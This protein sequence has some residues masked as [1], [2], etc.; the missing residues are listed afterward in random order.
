MALIRRSMMLDISAERA[1]AAIQEPRLLNHIAY[2]LQTFKPVDPPKLPAT[3]A[4]SRYKVRLRLFGVVPIGEQWIVIGIL[5]RGPDR[6]RMRDDGHGDLVRRWEHRITI[7]ALSSSRCRY[8]D[9]VEID[10]GVLTPLVAA[11]ASVFFRHRQRRWRALVASDFAPLA[12]RSTAM[13]RTALVLLLDR[14]M[15]AHGEARGRG[16]TAAAWRALERAHIVSQPMLGRHLRVHAA[17]L[18]YAVRL[19]DGREV[20][21][22]L[23]RLALAPLGALTGRTPWGNTGRSNVSAFKPMPPPEDLAAHLRDI[24]TKGT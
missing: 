23:A 8:T 17:M 10:A 2:P 13:N 14:E 1:W 22:Q 9:E 12:S 19:H 18:G 7:E 15:I 24:T 3:W 21:G 5:E 11:F 4:E 6:Y 20:L 16:H